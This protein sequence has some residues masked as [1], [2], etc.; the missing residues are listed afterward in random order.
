MSGPVRSPVR[1]PTGRIA[2]LSAAAVAGLAALGLISGCGSGDSPEPGPA[3]AAEQPAAE[4]DSEPGSD[5]IVD[6]SGTE[7]V[8]EMTAGSVASLAECRDWTGADTGERLATIA[9]I[10]SQMNLEDSGIDAPALTDEEAGELFDG[11][12]APSYAAGFRLYKLYARGVGFVELKRMLE[13]QG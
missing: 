3:A 13:A 5:E 6:I 4:R 10:R 11:A 8:G 2:E 7:P 12:C 1:S 9:D